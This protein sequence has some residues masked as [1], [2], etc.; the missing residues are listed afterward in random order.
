MYEFPIK[1]FYLS[2]TKNFKPKT[3]DSDK[4]FTIEK[5]MEIDLDGIFYLIL[6][7]DDCTIS[8]MKSE[9]F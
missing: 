2:E 3:R 6:L 1:K 9:N 4:I 5:I 7:F 8:M